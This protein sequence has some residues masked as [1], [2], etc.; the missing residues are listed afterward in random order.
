ME[1]ARSPGEAHSTSPE[2]ALS[3]WSDDQS[4][5]GGTGR[6]KGLKILCAL[7]KSWPFFENAPSNHDRNRWDKAWFGKPFPGW[8]PRLQQWGRRV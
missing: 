6:R 1:A 7:W 5:R 2:N 3:I 4:G 8:F